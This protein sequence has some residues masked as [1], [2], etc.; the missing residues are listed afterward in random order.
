MLSRHPFAMMTRKESTDANGDMIYL[1]ME[2][3]HAEAHVEPVIP[4]CCCEEG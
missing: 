2:I 3:F 1:S 4:G